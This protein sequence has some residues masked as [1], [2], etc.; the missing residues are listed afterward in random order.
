ML[1]DLPLQ[2]GVPKYIHKQ[3]YDFDLNDS[4]YAKPAEYNSLHDPSLKDYF[5]NPRTRRQLVVNDLITKD[6]KVK[7]SI[8]EFNEYRSV[9]LCF[10]PSFFQFNLNMNFVNFCCNEKKNCLLTFQENLVSLSRSI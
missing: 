9:T 7:C 5:H 2:V 10:F 1:N 6:G 8:K 3:H 4:R